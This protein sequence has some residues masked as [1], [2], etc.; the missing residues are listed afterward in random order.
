V[1]I[2]D[3]GVGHVVVEGQG[4]TAG[5]PGSVEHPSEVTVL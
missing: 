1:V 2:P 4:L 5:V 3:V